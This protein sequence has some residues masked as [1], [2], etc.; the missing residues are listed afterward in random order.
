M[1]SATC[2]CGAVQIEIAHPPDAVTNC[3]CSIC[4]RLGAL[5]AFYPVEAVRIGGDP[6]ATRAYQWGERTRR[7]VRCRHCGCVTHCE[8]AASQ[9]TRKLE[10]NVRMFDP[11]LLGPVRVRPFDGAGAWKYLDEHA[12][13]ASC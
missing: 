1:L 10:V 8:P 9:P 7:F 5:W 2:H 6:A 4:R 13:E 11:A 3:N 12:A